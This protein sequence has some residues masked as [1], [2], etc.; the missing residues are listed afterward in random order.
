MTGQEGT[1]KS[2]V[3]ERVADLSGVPPDRPSFT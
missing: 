1:R 2:L 3:E